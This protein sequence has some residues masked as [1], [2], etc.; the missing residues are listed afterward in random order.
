M[1]VY[2]KHLCSKS[3]NTSTG[4]LKRLHMIQRAFVW[5][6]VFNIKY[7]LHTVN[8]KFR[9]TT[10]KPYIKHHIYWYLNLELRFKK[11]PKKK[12]L[13]KAFKSGMTFFLF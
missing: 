5:Y 11:C 9:I 4:S 3:P 10:V 12:E 13:S 2:N 8:Y 6:F 1:R 7:N